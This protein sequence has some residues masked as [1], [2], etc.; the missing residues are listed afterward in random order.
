MLPGKG[1]GEGLL[2]LY[3]SMYRSRHFE[4]YVR[5]FWEAGLITGEMHTG[6]G[7]EA[8]AA[9]VTHHLREGD[10]MALD[11][12]ST[13]PLLMRGVPPEAL[14]REFLGLESGL[15]RG[16]GGHM[17]LFSREHL[18]ASSG[19]VGSSGPAGLG[20]A[21]AA[22][23]LR[24]GAIGVAFFGEGA[25]NQGMLLEAMNLAAAWSSPLLFVCKDDGIAV[26]TPSGAVTAGDLVSRAR[27]FHLAVREVDGGDVAAVW[28]AAGDLISRAR[29]GEG[30]GWLHARC[31]HPEGHMLGD[32]LLRAAEAPL[33][34]GLP[35]LLGIVKSALH[36]RGASLGARLKAVRDLSSRMALAARYAGG[37]AAD[38]VWQTRAVLT[39]AGQDVAAIEKEV[40]DEIRELAGR[41][42]QEIERGEPRL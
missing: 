4:Q 19:I 3:H 7:E 10:G 2:G 41:I 35:I 26:T 34:D 9:G 32:P 37:G 15:C 12:R 16:A 38:P 23:R 40:H 1:N 14:L 13:P 27:A 18:A 8:I 42:I 31:A 30:A 20:F 33:A 11:Y 25:A 24:P 36:P 5:I 6:I 28:R 29:V 22:E 17:H 21:L 39:A